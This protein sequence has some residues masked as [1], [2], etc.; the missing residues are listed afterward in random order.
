MSNSIKPHTTLLRQLGMVAA[1]SCGVSSMIGSGIFKKPAVMAYELGSPQLLILV[2]IVT[3]IITLFGIMTIAEVAGMFNEPGGLYGYFHKGYN[4]FTGYIYGWAAFAVIQ[5]GSIASIA[6]VFSDSFGHFIPF[7]RLDTATEAMALN[8]PFIG[9]ITPFKFLGLKLCTIGVILFLSIVNYFGVKY[10][11]RVQTVFAGIKIVV[12]S[13]IIILSFVLGN[14]HTANFTEGTGILGSA[15]G[16]VFLAFILAMSGAFWAYDGWINVTF[17]AGEIKNPQKVLPRSMLVSIVI[18]ISVY[19]LI[20]LAYLYLIP[21][22]E[23]A[24]KY[25]AAKLSGGTYLV[26]TDVVSSFW[27]VWGGK[28]IAAAIMISTFGAVNGSIMMSS[29]IYYAMAKE[30]MFFKKI[31]NIHSKHHT[32]ANSLLL[33]GAWAAMLVLS[34][35][36]DQLTDMLIW[37]GWIFYALA[38]Y[39]VFMLRRKMPDAPRPYKVWG[40]PILPVLFVLFSAIFIF[41]VLYSDITAYIE[42]RSPLINSLM[43][44]LLVALGLPGYF[45]WRR[46]QKKE[47]LQ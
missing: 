45:Y 14:G 5:T 25:Q 1:I 33:Q 2:W 26:A 41:F 42:G 15:S 17:M 28:I 7:L 22:D 8:I 9:A 46:K 29:R 18:V 11:G 39:A 37:V 12:I 31:G 21:V 23:M 36:F 3:G 20:N 19:V 13:A 43:G 4:K 40:Y 10:G 32:P 30:G 16:S 47:S 27:G 44:A 24:S 38:G 6:Y 35:T 34:G